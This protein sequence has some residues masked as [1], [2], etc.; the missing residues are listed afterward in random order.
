MKTT[1]QSRQQLG[2]G[3]EPLP[4]ENMPKPIPWIGC[5]YDGAR[6]PVCSGYT[7]KMPEV[8]EAARAWRH[9]NKGELLSFTR[10]EPARPLTDS[11]EIFDNA[12]SECQAW[13]MK[14]KAEGGGGS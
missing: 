12:V 14:P 5:G 7:T 1:Q 3:F 10:T 13:Q 9:W 11:I 2:C 8:I 4:G 6:P